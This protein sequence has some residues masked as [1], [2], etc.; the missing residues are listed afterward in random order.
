MMDKT[1][2]SSFEGERLEGRA[3][4]QNRSLRDTCGE[5][6]HVTPTADQ[7]HLPGGMPG[8]RSAPDGQA[9]N[10]T[11]E[12]TASTDTTARTAPPPELARVGGVVQGGGEGGKPLGISV[13]ISRNAAGGRVTFYKNGIET[14]RAGKVQAA[15]H[16]R[17]KRG[18]VAGWSAHSRGRLRRVLLVHQAPPGWGQYNVTLTVPGPPLD[19]AEWRELVKGFWRE[20]ARCG[21]AAIWRIELQQRGQPHLH[22]LVYTPKGSGYI[23]AAWWAAVEKLGP[24]EGIEREYGGQS[25]RV[26]A[27]S[28]MQ[29]PGAEKHAVSVAQDDGRDSWFRYLADHT[30]KA[31]QAQMGWVGRQWGIVGRKHILTQAAEAAVDLDPKEWSRFHRCL[32]RLTRSRKWRGSKGRSVWFSSPVTMKRLVEW[33]RGDVP[34]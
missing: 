34:F 21:Y 26:S 10:C 16:Q 12:P 5:V 30:S 32:R 2:S 3:E 29:L 13:H 11:C 28:R 31:K 22:A 7:S 20:I 24:V 33:A 27:S 25:V 15:G 14:C 8:L 23:H 9:D 19:A 17:V 4:A 6:A 18:K 1:D